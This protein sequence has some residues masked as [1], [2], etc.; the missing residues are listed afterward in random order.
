MPERRLQKILAEAGVASRRKAEEFLRA[1]RVKVNGV[2][3]SLGDKAD[4]A[5]DEILFDGAPVR[6]DELVYLVLNKPQ[7]VLTTTEDTHGR[8]TVLDLLPEKTPRVF[9]VGRLD[10]DTEGL[11]LLTNDGDLAHVLLHPS[12]GNEREYRVTVRGAMG[13]RALAKLAKGIELEDGPSAPTRVARVQVDRKEQITRLHMT[14]VE[15]RKRQIRRTLE[16]L[17]HPVIK[18]VRV[19]MGPLEL[20]RLG[21]GSVRAL[22]EQEVEVLLRHAARLRESVAKK[23]PKVRGPSAS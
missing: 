13:E 10:L 22:R 9:P 4:P 17:G 2:P 1:G 19:R 3:A 20:G 23:S 14:L 7:G 16:A 6:P 21:R 12:L 18:L 8:R 5:R 11:L 15:G